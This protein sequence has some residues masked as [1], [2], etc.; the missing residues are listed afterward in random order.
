MELIGK[1]MVDF[2]NKD[3]ERVQGVKLHLVGL[4]NKVSGRACINHFINKNHSLYDEFMSL[5]LGE[6]LIE[7]G[8]KGSIQS[9]TS[10]VRQ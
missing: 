1:Q 9:V 10:L 6:V 7:Y 3:G 5:P 8:Y 4:D 2:V